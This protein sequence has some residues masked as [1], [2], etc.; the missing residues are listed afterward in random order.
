MDLFR[1][2]ACIKFSMYNVNR[3]DLVKNLGIILEAI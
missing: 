1:S 3:K 2:L